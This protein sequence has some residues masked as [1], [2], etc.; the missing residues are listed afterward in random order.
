MLT[1]AMTSDRPYRDA[2]AQPGSPNA[3]GSGRRSQFDTFGNCASFEA[4]LTASS[5]DYRSGTRLD[6]GLEGKQLEP[7]ETLASASLAGGA[8][9]LVR[10]LSS[11][12][13]ATASVR[14]RTP[15]F[16]KM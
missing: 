11:L 14:V 15:S 5:E 12:V 16:S 8:C 6:F 3:S 9:R 10:L 13:T 4:I 2:N 1:N 7:D